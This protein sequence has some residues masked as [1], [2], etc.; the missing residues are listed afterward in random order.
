MEIP[1]SNATSANVDSMSTCSIV[2]TDCFSTIA[3]A[4]SS[5]FHAR[6]RSVSSSSASAKSSASLVSSPSSSSFLVDP[7][8]CLKMEL[9]LRN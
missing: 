1:L 5:I 6:S 4:I 7:V 2:L 8:S 3:L 9:T